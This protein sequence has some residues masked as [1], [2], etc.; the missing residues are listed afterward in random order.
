[1]EEE[2]VFGKKNI[3]KDDLRGRSKERTK[4]KRRLKEPEKGK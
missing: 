3:R 4:G 2:E 1:M